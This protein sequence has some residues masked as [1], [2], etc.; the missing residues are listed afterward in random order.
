ML[1]YQTFTKNGII[2]LFNDYNCW[3]SGAG[4]RINGQFFKDIVL[5][6]PNQLQKAKKFDLEL[7]IS[8]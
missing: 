3:E 2:D 6:F 1:F 5:N 7:F 8:D 4:I